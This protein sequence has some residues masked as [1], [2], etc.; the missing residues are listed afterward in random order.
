MTQ[1]VWPH[2]HAMQDFDGADKTLGDLWCF[3]ICPASPPAYWNDVF[4]LINTLCTEIGKHMGVAFRCRR[5]VDIVSAGI[6]HPEIW[7]DIHSADLVIA[8]IT[9]RNGNVM[10]ELGVASAWLDKGRVIIIPE[11]LPEEARLFDVTPARQIDYTR[12]PSCFNNLA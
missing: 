12:S 8:D 10:I 9:G 5:A 6:I 3:V 7:R 1:S 11:D 4:A 2:D